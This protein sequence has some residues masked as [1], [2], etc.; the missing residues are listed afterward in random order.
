MPK[1]ALILLI[2][3]SWSLNAQEL[4]KMQLSGV[5]Q[6][7]TVFLQNPYNPKTKKFCVSGIRVNGR[8]LGLSL[9]RTALIID[10]KNIDR[11]APVFLEIEHNSSCKPIVINPDAIHFHSMFSFKSLN[12]NDSTITWQTNGEQAGADYVIEK[13]ELGVWREEGIVKSKGVF[14]D[15]E[16]AYFPSLDVGPNKYRIKYLKSD[17]WYL[18]SRELDFHYYPEPVTFYPYK[19]KSILNLSRSA[20]YEIFDAGGQLVMSGQGAVIDVTDLPTGDY[21]VY[22]DEKDPGLFKKL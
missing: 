4:L 21:V 19:T 18:Y 1:I 9:D 8:D 14:T 22:F 2:V 7:K 13:Y 10:F 16:Y 12:F 5:Y 11:F 20:A 15:A 17:D 3:C 6:G